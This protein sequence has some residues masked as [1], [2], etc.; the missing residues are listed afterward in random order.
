MF[1]RNIL[2]LISDMKIMMT[3]T[4]TSKQIRKQR[5][6]MFVDMADVTKISLEEYLAVIKMDE[7]LAEM[8]KSQ[9]GNP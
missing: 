7:K 2:K 1:K 5:N 9:R 8:E 4:K 6:Q 3:F